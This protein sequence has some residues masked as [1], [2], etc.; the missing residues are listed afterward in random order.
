VHDVHRHCLHLSIFD[1]WNMSKGR[2]ALHHLLTR[3]SSSSSFFFLLLLHL[4]LQAQHEHD[5]LLTR[6]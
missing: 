1:M 5:V 3:G 2:H 4:L 6:A